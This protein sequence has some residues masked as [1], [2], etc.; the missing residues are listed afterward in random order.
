MH[1]TERGGQLGDLGVQTR[2]GLPLGIVSAP[3]N[4]HDSPLLR[5]TLEAGWA[6]LHPMPDIATM[7]LD[8]SYDNT[9]CRD[10]LSELGFD[11]DI[12]RKGV[13][14]PIQVGKRVGC[15][16]HEFVDER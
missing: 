12:A 11:A 14:A 16:T 7:R 15:R 9:R 1:I 4:R 10:L 5:A 6:Q 8:R 13:A 2:S 3:A